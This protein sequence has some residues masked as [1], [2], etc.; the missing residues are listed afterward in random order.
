MKGNLHHSSPV[1]PSESV[2]LLTVHAVPSQASVHGACVCV[3]ECACVCVLTKRPSNLCI[4]AFDFF[5]SLT[6]RERSFLE[7][8][9]FS[10]G[11]SYES[12]SKAPFTCY[13]FNRPPVFVSV[14]DL[15][16]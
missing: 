13:T 3:C 1:Y 12:S 2:T 9:F 16:L 15:G 7:E 10:L 5:F 4:V 14:T 6:A 8:I 11:T